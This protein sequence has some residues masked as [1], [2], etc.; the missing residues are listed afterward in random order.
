[1]IKNDSLE[2]IA[3][4]VKKADSVYIFIHENMDGDAIGSGSALCTVLRRMGKTAY[5]V[6]NG[7][8]PDN[9]RFLD[10]DTC[11][12]CGDVPGEHDLSLAVDCGERKRFPDNIELFDQGKVT[13]CIDHHETDE[14]Q[15][16][17]NHV[18]PDAA[19]SGEL[20]FRFIRILGEELDKEEAESLFAAITTDTGNF[21]YS[22]TT[23]KTHL[24]TAELYDH[25]I[26]SS[27]VSNQIYET[28]PL[29]KM[30]LKSA[31][32]SRMEITAD[33][34]VAMT[35]VTQDMLKETGAVLNDSE[36]IVS[37]LRQIDGVEISALIKESDDGRVFVSLRSKTGANVRN[38]AMR[39]GGG[40]H[41]RAAGCTVEGSSWQAVYDGIKKA[42]SEEVL[43][44]KED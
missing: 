18:E 21:Q 6:K 37:E 40:G 33:G 28:V 11:V 26:D 5:V 43:G 15:F 38:V 3:E 22:N 42:A 30:R 27:K 41:I 36:G 7:A 20:I 13:A 1:M 25:G 16:D 19:A 23:K 32:M 29:R 2:K 39:F 10:R 44:E 4:E 8:I 24:I 35:A 34:R 9:L 12:D 17:L 14:A 31:A